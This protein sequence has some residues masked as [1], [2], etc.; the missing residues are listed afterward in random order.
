MGYSKKQ[1][2]KILKRELTQIPIK[3]QA[4]VIKHWK[5]ILDDPQIEFPA[6][7][8]NKNWITLTG[9]LK[10][11]LRVQALPGKIALIY[12][13]DHA[14]LV[15][16]GYVTS[17]GRRIPGRDY[18]AVGLKKFQLARRIKFFLRKNLEEKSGIRIK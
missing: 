11:S 1:I 9:E 17:T 6:I 7:T 18:F 13:A 10:Q 14:R 16:L 5:Y 12:N 4:D 15:R 3:L 2:K 8:P